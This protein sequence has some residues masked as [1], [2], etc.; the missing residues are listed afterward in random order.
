YN[1]NRFMKKAGFQSLKVFLGCNFLLSLAIGLGYFLFVGSHPAEIAFSIVAYLSN[2]AMIYAVLTAPALALYFTR[3]G[4]A[5]FAAVFA[6]LQL[7]LVVD[8]AVYKI[9]R[10]HINSMVVNLILTPGGL[11]SLDQ[12]TGMKILFFALALGLLALELWFYGLAM[13]SGGRFAGFLKKRTALI[14]GVLLFLFVLDKGLFAWGTLYDAVYITGNSKLFPLYQPLKIRTFAGK[15]L[16]VKLDSEVSV[17]INKKF[18]KLDYPK[19]E[20]DINPPAKPLNVLILVTDSFRYDMLDKEITPALWAFSKKASVFR[21]HY[22]GGNCTRFGIFSLIY[23]I[24]GNY[25]F[26]MA[27]E[28]RPPVL[29]DAFSALGYEFRILASAKL[30]FP[31]FN[32][33]CFAKVP[34]EDIYDEP[35]S[36]GKDG[37]DREITDKFLEFLKARTGKKPYFAFIFYDASHGSYEHP[38]EFEKFKP[39]GGVNYLALNKDN[40]HLLFNKYRNSL[41]YE[42]SLIGGILRFMEKNGDL[43]DT[44]VLVTGDHGE[45]FFEKGYFGHNQAYSEEEVKVPLVFYLP[46]RPPGAVDGLTSHMDIVPTLLKLIGTRN[47]PADYSSGLDLFEKNSRPFVSVFSWD[48]S[49]IIKDGSALVMPLEAY[50]GGLKIYDKDYKAIPGRK[51]FETFSPHILSFQ[52][53]AKRFYK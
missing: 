20:L 38:P 39:A 19:V 47:P 45:A 4:R 28:R 42:D 43:K 34:R 6:F 23:G 48:T 36:A 52:Q 35:K 7:A 14:A 1:T 37:K 29:L 51:A 49:A 17:R 15:Y 41:H 10:F 50:G 27:G 32:K 21:N 8:V 33:T 30:S 2:T 11:E 25:W 3:A 26:S 44:A 9:F 40:A 16:G 18:S 13:R 22:S 5:P 53:E 46:G 24:Y 12:G 31:E